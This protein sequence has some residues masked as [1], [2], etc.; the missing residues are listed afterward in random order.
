MSTTAKQGIPQSAVVLSEMVKRNT[1]MR[2][3]RKVRNTVFQ[4]SLPISKGSVLLKRTSFSRQVSLA[5]SPLS[6]ADLSPESLWT[7][8]CELDC[9][10]GTFAVTHAEE[11]S[12][13]QQDFYNGDG[14]AECMGPEKDFGERNYNRDCN[15]Q[16]RS[17]KRFGEEVQWQSEGPQTQ[18]EWLSPAGSHPW[19]RSSW[20]ASYRP[21]VDYPEQG[22]YSASQSDAGTGV[23]VSGETRQKEMSSDATQYFHQQRCQDQ[24]MAQDYASLTGS[25]GQS[26]ELAPHL[27]ATWINTHPHVGDPFAH[28]G[29]I[30]PQSRVQFPQTEHREW[31]EHTD[32]TNGYDQTA[33]QNDVM[34]PTVY[35]ADRKS[36]V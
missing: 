21:E 25:V 31:Q 9:D 5:C 28:S 8:D 33:Q 13:L 22:Y 34:Q 11:T 35:Q 10:T 14:D 27:D 29:N 23:N 4:V 3:K 24:Y 19:H 7:E 18:T 12:Q 36:V 30:A 15:S 17:N 16:E 20:T 26:G 6:G 1:T 32:L 2:K